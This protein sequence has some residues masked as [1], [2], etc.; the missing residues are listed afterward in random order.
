MN[1]AYMLR[2]LHEE[3]AELYGIQGHITSLKPLR[4]GNRPDLWEE[5]ALQSF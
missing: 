2:Q 1:P 4:P 5:K 3:F